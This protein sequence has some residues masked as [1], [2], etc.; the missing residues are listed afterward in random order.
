M[1]SQMYVGEE[2]GVSSEK[3]CLTSNNWQ[4]SHMPHRARSTH[5]LLDHVIVVTLYFSNKHL[6]CSHCLF[7][8]NCTL[9][10]FTYFL[11]FIPVTAKIRNLKDYHHRIVNNLAPIPSGVDI[12]NT[13][14]FFS[15]MLLR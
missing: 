9:F 5:P 13:L 10:L 4:L 8:I 7:T 2:T 14:K 1:T 15:Q 12:A 6:I 11:I 3:H